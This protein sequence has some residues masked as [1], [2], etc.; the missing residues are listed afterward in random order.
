M[1]ADNNL[2]PSNSNNPPPPY[3]PGGGSVPPIPSAPDPLPAP[4]P[5]SGGFGRFTKYVVIGGV[6]GG[7]AS[8]V[9]VLNFL[10]CFCCLLNVAAV[11]LGLHLYL[12]S[13]PGDTVSNGEA[14]GFGAA[15][16]LIGGLIS[17]VLGI[18]I[19]KA[20]QQGLLT[21][22]ERVDPN[23]A[24]Q[25]ADQMAQQTLVEQLLYT[26][27]SVVVFVGFGALGGV[28]AMQMLFKSRL[29]K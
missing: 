11:A 18:F 28:L 20:T 27:I 6:I 13:A 2:P 23:M 26:S 25:M 10:N 17:G 24:Q 19:G 21:F 9:P 22:M 14:A 16:G 3:T 5:F 7:V 8:S 1:S 4:V 29:R 12:K 15:S